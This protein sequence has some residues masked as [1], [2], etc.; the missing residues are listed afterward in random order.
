MHNGAALHQAP[1]HSRANRKGVELS[2]GLPMH[3]V[4]PQQ[5]PPESLKTILNNAFLKN[6]QVSA[7]M[8]HGN[9]D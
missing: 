1:A 3:S 7:M 4:G 8:K 5:T 6:G 2:Q 9:P